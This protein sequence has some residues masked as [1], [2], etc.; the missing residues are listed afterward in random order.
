[1]KVLML[2]LDRG[3]FGH[4]TS[5]DVLER[6][7]KYADA[8]GFLDIIVFAGRS[9][10]NKIVSPNLRIFPTRSKKFFHQRQA[11]E[12]ARK[13]ASDNQ[14]DLLVTQDFASPAGASVKVFFG[15]PWVVNIHSMFFSSQW[16]RLNPLNWY[17]MFR[18]KKAVRS[19]DGFRVNNEAIREKLISWGIKAPILVQPTPIDIERFRSHSPRRTKGKTAGEN[20]I[21][22][23]LFVGRLAPEKNLPMLIEVAKNIK[24]NFELKIVGSGSEGGKLK[25]LAQGDPR[26]E[27]L[28]PK[29]IEE[30]PEIFKS[31]DIFVLPSHTE[32]FGQV[33]LQAAASG[34]AIIATATMGANNILGDNEYGKLVPVNSEP[35]LQ[36]ALIELIT[37]Q[38]Q[39]EYWQGRAQELA[40]RY[41]STTGVART[42]NFWKE[43]AKK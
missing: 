7:R 3:L 42:I 21:V 13:L 37:T 6:H 31:A 43:I 17:L 36:Q 32:S 40:S 23:L 41:D 9:F 5:G 35:D 24:E 26:I 19:A 15:I 8:A 33:L 12:L 39:R 10:T 29:T 38:Y 22:Q 30:L 27:F 14:Y 1:M 11:F 34:C 25:A 20:A 2:S 28:G 18:I 16:L 4:G